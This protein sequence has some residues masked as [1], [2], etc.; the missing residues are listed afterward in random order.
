MKKEIA[1]K[2]WVIGLYSYSS[3]Q[4]TGTTVRAFYKIVTDVFTQ[5]GAPP[6][7]IAAEGKGYSGKAVDFGGNISKKLIHSDFE[8]ITVL[9]ISSNPEGSK[10][11]AYDRFATASLSFN[12]PGETLLCLALNEGFEPFGG[13][14][15]CQIVGRLLSL[16]DWSFGF[17]FS[18]KVNRQPDFHVLGIDNGKLGA[19]EQAALNAWYMA[20]PERKTTMLRGVYPMML[21]NQEQMQL[22]APDGRSL[23]EY[24]GSRADCTDVQSGNLVMC[25]IPLHEVDSMRAELSKSGA[26]IG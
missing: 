1:D 20:Q 8:D 5:L 12:M 9:D 14:V 22:S 24:I 2:E 15:F 26:L 16:Q 18:D 4:P 11:P 17:G 23:V 7:Y 10:S 19:D 21:L 3:D 25:M 6:T 13:E